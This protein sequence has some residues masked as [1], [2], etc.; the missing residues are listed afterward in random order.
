MTA[1]AALAD[2][3]LN[4]TPTAACAASV[5]P[6]G[7]EGA[8]HNDAMLVAGF[9]ADQPGVFEALVEAHQGKVIR[10]AHRLLGWRSGPDV[11][12]IV[13][14]VFFAALRHRRRFRGQS[15]LGTWLSAITVNCCRTHQRR[16]QLRQ[17]LL[18]R[19]R[20]EVAPE[21][22]AS[23]AA[24]SND[25][26]RRVR[27]AVQALPPRDREVVVLRYF[28]E[29]DAAGIAAVTGLSK[30]AVEVRLHRAR[31]RLAERLGAWHREEQS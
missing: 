12:D 7:V 9:V 30:N 20:Q 31:A 18:L 2:A 15:S 1:G 8:A 28:E 26:A 24:A 5:A 10:L 21:P 14:E 29:L 17:L 22:P 27:Q 13:Q 3:D 19:R 25:A 11:E 16:Q 4:F 23:D 6:P